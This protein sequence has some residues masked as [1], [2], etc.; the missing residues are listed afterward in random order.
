M[1]LG[2]FM[3]VKLCVTL[4]TAK[5]KRLLFLQCHSD[6]LNPSVGSTEYTNL[7]YTFLCAPAD[8]S[9]G[10]GLKKVENHWFVVNKTCPGDL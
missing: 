4:I 10:S 2:V 6:A 7:Q 1:L 8:Y 5:K 9:G 3:R